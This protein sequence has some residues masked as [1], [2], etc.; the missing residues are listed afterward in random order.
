VGGGGCFGWRWILGLGFPF[1]LY[2]SFKISPL[3]LS[4]GP[5]FIGKILLGP[6]NWSLNFPFFVNFDFSC[7]F[8][9]FLKTSNINIDSMRKINAFKNDARKIE[10]VQK[11]FE[12]LNSFL[13]DVENAKNDANIL[14]TYFLDFRCFS[15]FFWIFQKFYQKGGSKIG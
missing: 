5:I 12:N 8:L 7:F 13:D 15:L 4:C 11:T 2:F 14:K 1:F 6:Q 10:R 9:Y 3:V